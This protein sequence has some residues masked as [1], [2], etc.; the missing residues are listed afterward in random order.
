[1]PFLLIL[2]SALASIAQAAPGPLDV[3]KLNIGQPT[4]VAELDLGKL[5]G[6]LREICWSEDGRQIY[7]QTAEGDPRAA[8]PHHYLIALPTGEPAGVDKPPAWAEDY[9]DFKASK[10]APGVSALVIQFGSADGIGG[11]PRDGRPGTGVDVAQLDAANDT[12]TGTRAFRLL[13][14]KIGE[15]VNDV[16]IPGLSYGWGPENSG[17]IAF[18]DHDGKVILMDRQKHKTAIAATKDATLPAWSADGARL[19]WAQKTGRKK[20]MLMVVPVG[21]K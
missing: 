17:A 10:T 18:V 6:D 13:G 16:P 2:A 9:W 8:K 11:L 7:V 14:E 12:S 15:V 1:M 3:S 19:A 4:P 20:Y 5:K 21:D